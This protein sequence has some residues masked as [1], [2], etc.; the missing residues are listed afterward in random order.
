VELYRRED[1]PRLLGGEVTHSLVLV[2]F[3]LERLRADAAR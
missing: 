2:A 3:F 1:L